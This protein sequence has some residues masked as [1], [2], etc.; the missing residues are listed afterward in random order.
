M[1]FSS[2]LIRW[3]TC[4]V[5]VAIAASATVLSSPAGWTAEGSTEP[6]T[7]ELMPRS[8]SPSRME[9]DTPVAADSDARS[10]GKPMTVSLKQPSPVALPWSVAATYSEMTEV[11]AS[12]GAIAA[13]V[14]GAGA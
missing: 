8:P 14:S 2:P 3:T 7:P 1:A 10:V 6:S 5:S 4:G 13:S 11:A 12:P 9:L